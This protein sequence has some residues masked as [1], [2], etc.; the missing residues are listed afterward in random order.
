MPACGGSLYFGGTPEEA[1]DGDQ[2]LIRGERRKLLLTISRFGDV[3][4]Q[5]VVAK[6][7][8]D[9]VPMDALFAMLKAVGADTPQDPEQLSKLLSD[10]A[11]RLKSL[12]DERETMKTGDSEIARLSGLANEAVSEGALETAIVFRERAKER[13]AT[14]SS[15]VDQAESDLKAKRAEFAAVFGDSGD[16]YALAY[17]NAPRSRGFRQGLRAGRT[18]GPSAGAAATSSRRRGRW[19]TSA[20]TRPTTRQTSGPAKLIVWPPRWRRPTRTPTPGPTPRAG[21]R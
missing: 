15:T 16:T 21:L 4:R 13:V 6:A 18:L 19:P 17:D 12:L 10:Q 14:L 9:G 3:Q 5:Q 11:V 20:F 8:Q 2:A 1:G 7:E